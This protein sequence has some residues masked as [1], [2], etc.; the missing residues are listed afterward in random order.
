MRPNAGRRRWKSYEWRDAMG[1]RRKTIHLTISAADAVLIAP[2][3]WAPYTGFASSKNSVTARRTFLGM[4][5]FSA[6]LSAQTSSWKK[7]SYIGGTIPGAPNPYDWNTTL[8]VTSRAI[9]LV[10]AHGKPVTVEPSRV[11]AL[12]YGEEAHRR[13]AAMVALSVM[14]FNPAALFGILHSSKEHFIG[15]EF[16]A[17]D[18][19]PA[20]VLLQAH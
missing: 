15:I 18:G 13:V 4:V 12:S 20:S 7:I 1:E 17:E 6:L 10:I 19:K 11:I 2:T 9:T 3:A 16:R 8:T 5:V 14:T